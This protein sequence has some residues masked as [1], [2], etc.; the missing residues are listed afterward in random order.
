MELRE[1][2]R[3]CRRRW[4]WI[5]LPVLLAAAAAAGLT[6][7]AAPAYRSSMVLFV[8]TGSGDPD[9]KASRLNSYIALLTGPRVAES[10]ITRLD[11]PLNP[12][13]VQASL[14][15]QVQDGTDLLV[16]T[17]T[18]ASADR[19]E[20]IV[21]AATAAL[22]SLAK[23]LDPPSAAPTDGPAP[24]VT[25]AQNPVTTRV[26]GNVARNVGFSAVL[27]LLIGAIAVAVREA[28]G[29]TVNEED[30][31][32]RLG[33]SAVG[34]ISL[35]GRPG[36]GYPDE[37]LAEAFRRLRSLLPDF[38]GLRA[39][40]DRGTSL[41]LTG[42]QPKEGT[43]AVACGLAIAMAETG[44]SVVLVDAN[45]RTPG[46]GRYLALDTSRGLADVLSGAAT[47]PDVLQD[48]LDGRLT[49]LPSGEQPPDP[50]E[51]LA[52]PRLG[53]TLRSLTERFDVVI[54]DA[55]PLHGVADAAVLSKVTD[56]ALLV[57][58]A[59][60]TRTADVE[61]SMD[62]LTRVGAKLAGAVLNALPK[63]LP[64]GTAWQRGPE[65]PATAEADMVTQL[66]GGDPDAPD[67]PGEPADE[68]V[69]ARPHP[70]VRGRAQVVK[71]TVGT[72]EE[73]EEQPRDESGAAV[74]RGQAKVVVAQPADEIARR[75]PTSHDKSTADEE[76][77]PGE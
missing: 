6:L 3:A 17:A 2:V 69:V 48:S 61:R 53:V 13:E 21:T 75:E 31:L 40:P 52:S 43:T 55:P 35:G 39:E 9:A 33:L 54:V 50:G 63:K 4:L 76:P 18:D 46:V 5:V 56:G 22:I 15:A 19:S 8:T 42:A 14:A 57:V 77:K 73:A 74:I 27:G 16:V 25:I 49:V 12:T 37:A 30:D 24:S 67:E 65:V 26:P 23:Q 68:P 64:T 51:I 34:V 58:R 41:L 59:H 11:L 47:V 10:V 1:Y 38:A 70:T 20:A 32:R 62:L 36:R 71:A 44:A 45:L 66:F 29:K 60:R 28:T 7:A 72:P